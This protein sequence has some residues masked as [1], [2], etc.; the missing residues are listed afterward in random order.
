MS[1]ITIED[2]LALRVEEGFHLA[3]VDPESTP[4]FNG[5]SGDLE[6]AFHA[7]DD[8]LDELQEKLFAN[9]RAN[10]DDAGSI[11]LVLQGMDTSGKGGVIRHVVKELDPQG[12]HTVGFGRPTDEEAAHD[13]LW[14]F[15]P[16]LPLP[17]MITVYDRSHY[18]DVLVQRVKKLAP[19]EEIERRYGAIID[20]ESELVKN[21]TRIIKVM[22][23][24]SRAFQKHNLLERLERE[25]KHW[26]YDPGDLEDRSLWELYQAAYQIAMV[27]T[28]TK[29]APWYCV[30]S[31][32]KKYARTIVKAL[33]VD[34]MQS[35]E[36]KWPE[37]DFDPEEER[38]RLELS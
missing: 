13:F 1:D 10:P 28:S 37:Q 18:E 34:A 35:M 27:R 25:D 20:F 12:V 30:P 36:L 6:G 38:H 31:D 8:D 32:N 26:K 4:G 33:L 24:I 29:R 14:R 15:E 22:L 16:H 9:G 5:D 2:A 11:L 19:P 3:D 7:F 23:H 17:G 21:G